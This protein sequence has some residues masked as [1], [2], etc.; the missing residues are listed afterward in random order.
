M[1]EGQFLGPG[2]AQAGM[3]VRTLDPWVVWPL[4]GVLIGQFARSWGCRGHWPKTKG[5]FCP[6]QRGATGRAT[7]H[8]GLW[9]PLKAGPR[10]VWVDMYD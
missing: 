7:A 2:G 6:S 8:V 10:N 9:D 5:A 3:G 1:H 4:A